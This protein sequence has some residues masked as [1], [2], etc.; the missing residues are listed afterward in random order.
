MSCRT[1]IL[2]SFVLKA[3]YA[4]NCT[5]SSIGG[6]SNIP[7]NTGNR[8]IEK[9]YTEWAHSRKYH[10]GKIPWQTFLDSEHLKTTRRWIGR[11]RQII[12]SERSRFQTKSWLA[13]FNTGT[14]LNCPESHPMIYD[15]GD[16][17]WDISHQHQRLFKLYQRSN[18]WYSIR[19]AGLASITWIPKE[20]IVVLPREKLA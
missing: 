5:I 16:L 2:L 6:H 18:N 15:L 13:Q 1:A 19:G 17:L 7:Y 8:V 10:F 4:V 14:P 12:L 20:K 11:S 3:P 9:Y